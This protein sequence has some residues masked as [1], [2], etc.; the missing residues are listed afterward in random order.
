VEQ[1][2]I[3]RDHIE[4][5]SVFYSKSLYPYPNFCCRVHFFSLGKE[6]RAKGSINGNRR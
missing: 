6:E 2:Y 5:H 3:D 4:D 1:H